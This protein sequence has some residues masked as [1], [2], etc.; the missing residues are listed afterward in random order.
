MQ[1]RRGIRLALVVAVATLIAEA[2][3]TAGRPIPGPPTPAPEIIGSV[4][5]NGEPTSLAAVQGRVVLVEF[6][7]FG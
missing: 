4:W 5:I 1:V 7:T 6:W 3:S 2:I